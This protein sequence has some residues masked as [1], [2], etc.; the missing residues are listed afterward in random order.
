M[1]TQ[2]ILSQCTVHDNIVKLPDRQLDR[3]TEYMPVKKQHELIGGKW[4]GGKTAGFVFQS[5]PTELLAEIAKREKRNL[6]KEY[7]FFATPDTHADYLVELA[8]IKGWHRILEPSAGQGAIIKAIGRMDI[9]ITDVEYCEIMPINLKVLSTVNLAKWLADDFLQL[10][11]KP[12][13]DRIIANPPFT[14]N[15]D[16]THIRKM[17]EHLSEG[18]RLVSCASKHWQLSTNKVETEFRE[19]LKQVKAEVIEIEAGTFKDSGTMIGTV[20]IIIDKKP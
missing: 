8:E 13:Y 9:G 7:Q 18:G 15:Q 2:E 6:K 4:K 11:E 19:W 3:D 12:V 17:H 16:V 10:E 20:V 1:T 14:K 5:D